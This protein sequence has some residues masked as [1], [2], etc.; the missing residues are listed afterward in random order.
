MP[1][2]RFL[3]VP[4][5]LYVIVVLCLVGNAHANVG[6][7]PPFASS[8]VLQRDAPVPVWGT[9]ASG[10]QITVSMASQSK[11]VATP[12]SGKWTVKLDPMPAGGP[13]RTPS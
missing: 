10:E 6:V 11:S 4:S 8:M 7:K 12:S 13:Y 3:V 1:K 9:A 5:L 2:P